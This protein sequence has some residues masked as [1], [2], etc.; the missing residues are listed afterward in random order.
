MDNLEKG[1]YICCL[2]LNYSTKLSNL[3][4]KFAKH[5]GEEFARGTKPPPTCVFAVELPRRR[6]LL[7]ENIPTLTPTV[8]PPGLTRR[9]ILRH[10]AGWALLLPML[11]ARVGAAPPAPVPPGVWTPV[12]KTKE[13][14]K[15]TPKRVALSDGRVLFVTRQSDVLLEAASA[16][17]THRG[18]EVGWQAEDKQFHCPC[19]GAVFA[20]DGKNIHGTR[21]QPDEHLPNLPVVPVRQK[22]G[23][24]Q[25]NLQAVSANDLKPVKEG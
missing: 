3:C 20:A 5:T 18:C 9:Q 24:V 6:T 25:V 8:T 19:H 15:G 10:A 23:V 16:K 1:A 13:F 21:R 4:N 17:C 2:L 7:N 11:G 22:S 12:G 14:L